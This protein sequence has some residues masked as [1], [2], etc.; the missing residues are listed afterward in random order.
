MPA[1]LR[2]R[3][4]KILLLITLLLPI[5][6]SS[7]SIAHAMESDNHIH[8]QHQCD[9]Y[10]VINLALNLSQA[11]SLSSDKAQ[12]YQVFSPL[13]KISNFKALPRTRSPPVLNHQFFNYIYFSFFI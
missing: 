7:L 10:D 9:L 3:F 1:F 5:G 12:C 11:L 6:L 8:E 2:L 4:H 13:G